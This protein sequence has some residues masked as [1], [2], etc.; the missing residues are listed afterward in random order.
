MLVGTVRALCLIRSASKGTPT[1]WKINLANG[2]D[3]Q[4]DG[5][6]A[7]RDF[8]G[9]SV[10]FTTQT[11]VYTVLVLGPC[12]ASSGRSTWPTCWFRLVWPSGNGSLF[13]PCVHGFE[14]LHGHIFHFSKSV[15]VSIPVYTGVCVVIVS[16][17][18]NKSEQVSIPVYHGLHGTQWHLPWL[19]GRAEHCS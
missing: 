8:H 11:P 6:L 13:R 10:L 3:T 9:P 1:R 4:G 17:C 15:K 7:S 19:V 16:S 18:F 12:L 2:S 5:E 14:P